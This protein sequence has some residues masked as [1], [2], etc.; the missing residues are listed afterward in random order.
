[1][2]RHLLYITT[3]LVACSPLT[4][5]KLLKFPA[6]NFRLDNKVLK[7]NGY[8][9]CEKQWTR[10]CRRVPPTY[11]PDTLSKYDEKYISAFFLYNDGYAYCTGALITAGLNRP[12]IYNSN[13]Y[14]DKLAEFNT[15]ESARQV[16]EEH[17]S[18]NYMGKGS[19][20]DK[21]VFNIK[22]DS[23]S[24]QVYESGSPTLILTEYKG[25]ISNDSTFTIF[26]ELS[27]YN[28]KKPTIKNLSDKYHFKHHQTKADSTN[29]LRDN[30]TKLNK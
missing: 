2:K 5:N 23:I 15:F 6:D 26:K 19:L 10:Y 24:F 7:T 1:M 17:L 13:D 30:K 16:F 11:T 20:H 12:K 21:G 25:L 4:N 29:Y 14:C 28:S 9:Y 22:G 8:Y 3:F 18:K 27:Y